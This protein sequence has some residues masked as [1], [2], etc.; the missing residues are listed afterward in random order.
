MEFISLTIIA[1]S[2]E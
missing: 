1:M 2:S